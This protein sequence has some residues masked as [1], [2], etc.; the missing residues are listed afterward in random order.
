[1]TPETAARLGFFAGTFSLMTLWEFLAPKRAFKVPRRW[2]WIGNLGMM[3]LDALLLRLAMPILAFDLARLAEERGWG[4]LR[5]VAWNFWVEI[6]L[7]FV[8]LDLAIYA[9]HWIFHRLPWLW[10][11]H[12]VH[13]TD[14]DLDATSGVRFHPIEMLL[15]AA[16]KLALVAGLGAH[17]IA[18]LAFEIALNATSLFNH[19]NI[20]IPEKLEPWLRLIV[21]TPDMHRVHHSVLVAETDSNFGF[22]LPCWDRLFGTYAPKPSAG[23][24]GMELGLPEHRDWKRQ[25]LFWLLALPFK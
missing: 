9:Q 15:S 5:L 3:G 23:A 7:A 2:R 21:V 17:F 14:L 12:Q 10:R 1:M 25:R 22:N 8:L 16:L 13:H 11:L 18:V 20:R 6:A 4:L 19:A 24:L